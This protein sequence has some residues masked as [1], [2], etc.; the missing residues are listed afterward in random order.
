MAPITDD[1]VRDLLK[2]LE[3]R[4]KHKFK[5]SATIIPFERK[6]PPTVGRTVRGVF[7][8]AARTGQR[9]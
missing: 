5:R 8:Y 3:V 7:F 2:G 6:S 1:V 9:V 4:E